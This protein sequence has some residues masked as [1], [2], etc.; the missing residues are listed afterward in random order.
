RWTSDIELLTTKTTHSRS[1]ILRMWLELR[2]TV[3]IAY[4]EDFYQSER[5]TK[6]TIHPEEVCSTFGV[7]VCHPTSWDLYELRTEDY[8]NHKRQIYFFKNQAWTAVPTSLLRG[9]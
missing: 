2:E 4:W 5:K 7:V 3:R 9:A 8:R 1:L 6:T